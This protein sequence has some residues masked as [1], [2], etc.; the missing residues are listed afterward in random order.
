MKKI[1]FILF[2]LL[3]IGWVYFYVFN[4]SFRYLFQSN[5]QISSGKIARA[6]EILE[7]GAKKFPDNPKIN[8]KLAKA[9][10]LLGET[11]LANKT[12]LSKKPFDILK[13][14]KDFQ[15][16]LVD[17]SEANQQLGNEGFARLFA[18]KY[19][20]CQNL[21]E[22]SRRV[23]KNYIRVG[24]VLPEKSIELWQKAY[25]IAYALKESELKESLKALILPRYFQIISDLR[26]N[27]K[28]SEALEVLSKA[29]VIC[30]NAE[31]NYQEAL[32]Y[33]DLGK[34]D[35]AQKKF[36]EAIQLEPENEN[37]RISYANALKRVAIDTKDQAKKTE[38]FEKIKLLL[39][40]GENSPRKTNLLKKIIYLNAK[41]RITDAG[42]K[43]TMVGNYFYPSFT[44]KVKPVSDAALKDY[45]IIFSDESMNELDVYEAPIVDE[46]LN[47]TIEVTCRNPIEENNRVNAQLFLNNEFVKE[48]SNK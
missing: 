26:L 48:Y 13:D 7:E 22:I 36:E 8:Y 1:I 5:A 42:L 45:R 15:N 20:E 34:L 2:F 44:F 9:Y 46:E 10:L 43:I 3:V 19:L 37:Y 27:K 23:V 24:Q 31:V 28:Y 6:I 41:Y 17:L 12:I 40:S 25:S 4:T 16:L 21:N 11:E 35:L 32:V 18:T 38:Y 39:S 29:K 47:Q 14:N 30:K 33:Y